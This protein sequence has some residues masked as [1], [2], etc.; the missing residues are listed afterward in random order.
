[1]PL[2][3]IDDL[4]APPP[5]RQGWPWTEA[6]VP[7]ADERSA[8][9]PRLTIVTPSLDQGEFLE[10]AIRSV[11]LQGYPNLEYVVRDGGS[12]DGSREILSRYRAF[13]SDCVIGPDGGPA[14]ALN[15][16]FAA[17]SGEVFGYL[18]SDDVYEPG[19]LLALA[20][21]FG[22]GAAWTVG[23]ASYVRD[24][25]DLG[26]V[27]QE[28][29]S[30]ITEWFWTCPVCQPASLWS[31]PLHRSLGRLREDLEVFFDYELWMRMRFRAGARP[32]RIDRAVAR[33]RLHPGAK[34]SRQRARFAI[35]A[36]SIRAEYAESLPRLARARIRAA[37]RRMHARRRGKLALGLLAE[38]RLGRAAVELAR[39]I[40]HWPPV[41]LE[42][43]TF[44]ALRAGSHGGPEV[45]PG[46]DE[47]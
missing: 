27:P 46:W 42:P 28:S 40:V 16:G 44:R 33:Y 6:P 37:Q 31:A 17:A 14:A 32:R 11:L 9:L 43:S 10:E 47:F 41:L 23:E 20:R 21:P 24:G 3:R 35:E 15:E 13:L 29:G 5:A 30:G 36:K 7:V 19:A 18:N 38:R 4:P 39:A 26:R 1:M 12:A 2:V 22:A 8:E 25:I 45:W 34:T